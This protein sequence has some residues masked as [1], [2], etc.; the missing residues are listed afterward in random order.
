MEV[1]L[2]ILSSISKENSND[3]LR[4]SLKT[5]IG[6]YLFDEN[7]RQSWTTIQRKVC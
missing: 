6:K 4:F 2:A 1:F 7:D 3:N 5:S